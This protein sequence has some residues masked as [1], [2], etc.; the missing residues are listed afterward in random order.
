ML[1]SL[2]NAVRSTVGQ[3]TGATRGSGNADGL[4][5][6]RILHRELGNG[7]RVEI[8]RSTPEAT[9]RTMAQAVLM[10]DVDAFQA[11]HDPEAGGIGEL[12]RN[13]DLARKVM[14]GLNPL[15][16]AIIEH[17]EIVGSSDNRKEF[18]SLS[19]GFESMIVAM[20]KVDQNWVICDARPLAQGETPSLV[21]D[22]TPPPTLNGFTAQ[23]ITAMVKEAAIA[24]ARGEEWQGPREPV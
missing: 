7:D 16:L 22:Q 23:E 11:V 15:D 3:W 6:V 21:E 4:E 14:S 1:K 19:P 18:V 10:K 24:T 17:K 13:A 8:N 20:R 2:V 12:T 9:F 5:Y